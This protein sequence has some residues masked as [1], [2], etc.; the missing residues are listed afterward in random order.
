M[1][2]INLQIENIAETIGWV[3]FKLGDIRNFGIYC[4]QVYSSWCHQFL[5]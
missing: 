5:N 2:E 4:T 3:L 1:S